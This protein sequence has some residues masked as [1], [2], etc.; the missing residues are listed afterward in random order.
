MLKFVKEINLSGNELQN[1]LNQSINYYCHTSYKRRKD[2][3]LE[4][5]IIYL[6]ISKFGMNMPIR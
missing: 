4:F 2:K 6:N 3:L 1:D 5:W